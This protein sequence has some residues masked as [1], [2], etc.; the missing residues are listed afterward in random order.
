VDI[1]FWH[2]WKLEIDDMGYVI[3]VNATC[4]NIGRH[5]NVHAPSLEAAEGAVTLALAAIAMDC[6]SAEA[7]FLKVQLNPVC[8][9]LGA[10]EHDG[11]F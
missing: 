6:L 9:A 2:V 5:Q 4:S 8:A 3:D 11:A 7:S 1:A 10:G